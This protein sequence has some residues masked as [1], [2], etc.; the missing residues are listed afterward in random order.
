MWSG[1]HQVVAGIFGKMEEVLVHD[2]AHRVHPTIVLVR[3]AAPVTVP[4]RERV[5]RTRFEGVTVHVQ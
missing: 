1:R 2:A 3:V 5:D 4:P